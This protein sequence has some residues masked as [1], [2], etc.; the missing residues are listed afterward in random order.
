MSSTPV[1][2]PRQ[3]PQMTNNERNAFMSSTQVFT[4]PQEP[5]MTNNERNA[6]M[7]STPVFTQPQEPQMSNNERN[8]L[9]SSTPDFTS[10]Q[11]PQI[12]ENAK[13]ITERFQPLPIAVSGPINERR[14]ETPLSRTPV[15]TLEQMPQVN[16]NERSGSQQ[17][18]P[19]VISGENNDKREETQVFVDEGS[20]DSM[21]VTR[22]TSFVFPPATINQIPVETALG[23][24]NARSAL[25][26][27]LPPVI[28]EPQNFNSSV[29][30]PSGQFENSVIP[31][32]F[33]SSLFRPQRIPTLAE[34]DKIRDERKKLSLAPI[35][36]M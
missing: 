32:R 36:K 10:P 34:L 16:N 11:E 35:D 21:Q 2:T 1:F 23:E 17:L 33:M 31:I 5:Q 7:S 25:E 26:Q 14:E 24:P 9:M 4:Q 15:P 19:I 12:N 29:S 20:P 18:E 27:H 30:I 3:E 8:A 13:D 6:F 28:E 22:E